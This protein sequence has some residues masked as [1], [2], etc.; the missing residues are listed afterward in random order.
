MSKISASKTA[1]AMLRVSL[2]KQSY[3]DSPSKEA[4]L[5]SFENFS[6][7][8]CIMHILTL[9]CFQSG[10]PRASSSQQPDPKARRTTV[11]SS[12]GSSRKTVAAEKQ[13]ATSS[14]TQ[15]GPP[16]CMDPHL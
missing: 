13:P 1:A 7:F 16:R 3:A 10:T 11:A 15:A 14:K 8:S 5:V 2:M 9:F 4:P 6:P 12:P